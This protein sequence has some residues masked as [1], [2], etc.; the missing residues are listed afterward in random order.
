MPVVSLMQHGLVAITIATSLSFLILE[1]HE[2]SRS[3]LVQ[4]EQDQRLLSTLD[5]QTYMY[6]YMTNLI[7]LNPK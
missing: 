6:I 3:S 2:G 1:T 4:Q 7:T 5:F